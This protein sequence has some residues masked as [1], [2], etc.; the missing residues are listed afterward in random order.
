MRSQ[1]TLEETAD[2]VHLCDWHLAL[3]RDDGH[4]RELLL[5]IFS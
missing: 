1:P 5:Q 2:A 4:A 3:R